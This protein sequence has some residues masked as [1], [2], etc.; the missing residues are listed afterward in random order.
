MAGFVTRGLVETPYLRVEYY[1]T[2]Q[3]TTLRG[4]DVA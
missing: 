2:T 1:H 3:S 4:E